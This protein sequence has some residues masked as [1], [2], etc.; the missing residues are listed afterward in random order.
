MSRNRIWEGL[1][2][3]LVLQFT[4]AIEVFNGI[5]REQVLVETRQPAEVLDGVRLRLWL[6]RD[7]TRQPPQGWHAQMY[8]GCLACSLP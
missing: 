2:G 8:K 4:G 1:D 6:V 5:F 7:Y 3:V